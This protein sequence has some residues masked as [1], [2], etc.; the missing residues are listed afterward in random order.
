VELTLKNVLFRFCF[1]AFLSGIQQF[2]RCST[3]FFGILF[4]CFFAFFRLISTPFLI[5][6]ATL[7]YGGTY[8]E[9]LRQKFTSVYGVFFR[10]FSLRKTKCVPE[11]YPPGHTF[12]R[13]FS[14]GRALILRSFPEIRSLP[15]LRYDA[16]ESNG[17]SG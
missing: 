11:E 17:R 12:F 9:N 13:V 4:L 5:V 6:N 3:V 10:I 2:S 15:I 8:F 7:S 1:C 14:R 16:R